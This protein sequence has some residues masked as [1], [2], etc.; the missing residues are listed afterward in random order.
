MRRGPYHPASVA[1]QPHLSL[2]SCTAG[3]PTVRTTPRSS[4][5][6]KE[7]SRSGAGACASMPCFPR[8]ILV[9]LLL[10]RASSEGHWASGMLDFIFL[11]VLFAF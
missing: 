7:G 8:S 6:T 4:S 10:L 3:T 5:S 1:Q 11:Y 9:S 2:R